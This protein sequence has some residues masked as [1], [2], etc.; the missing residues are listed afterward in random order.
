MIALKANISFR[1]CDAV[2][3]PKPRLHR[4]AAVAVRA[5]CEE[6][7]SI[8]HTLMHATLPLVFQFPGLG[9]LGFGNDSFILGDDCLV[10]AD[11]CLLER[12]RRR[13]ALELFRKHCRLSLQ[14]LAVCFSCRFQV[15]FPLFDRLLLGLCFLDLCAGFS[16]EGLCS[17]C[18][19]LMVAGSKGAKTSPS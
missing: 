6:S 19:V 15:F 5:C 13:L 1:V 4:S 3:V 18:S 9:C 14:L 17:L 7:Y 12:K 2:Q 11:F 8:W 16:L 10:L